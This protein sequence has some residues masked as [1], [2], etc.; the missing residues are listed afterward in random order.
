[1]PGCT[2]LRAGLPNQLEINVTDIYIWFAEPRP[3]YGSDGERFIR[4]WTDDPAKVASLRD[5]IGKE[6]TRYLLA[7]TAPA[8]EDVSERV[9]WS[10]PIRST[11][12][13]VAKE[14]SGDAQPE[15]ASHCRDTCN[16]YNFRRPC[17]CP[18]PTVGDSA[19]EPFGYVS[20]FGLGCMKRDRHVSIFKK[21]SDSSSCGKAIPVY[22]GVPP[23]QTADVRAMTDAARDVLAERAR[24]GGEEGFTLAHDDQHT[25]GSLAVAGACYALVDARDTIGGAW[26]WDFRWWKP[27]TP[28]RNLVKACALILAE[29]ERLDRKDSK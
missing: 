9:Y 3:V 21:M 28:R 25:D 20:E 26:P 7:T 23:V 18:A 13:A 4:A 24:H 29:I 12:P 11:A 1:M 10:E 5:A 6:P 2:G 27:T 15:R 19:G 22:L 8:V 16:F 14:A 17:V